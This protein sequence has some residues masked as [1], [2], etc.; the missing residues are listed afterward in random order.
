[1]PA[2]AEGAAG[3]CD[4]SWQHKSHHHH[5]QQQQ[6]CWGPDSRQQMLS[7]SSSSS[8]WAWGGGSRQRLQ[9]LTA[10]GHPPCGGLP[11]WSSTA[12]CSMEGHGLGASSSSGS[13][14][15]SRLSSCRD[16]IVLQAGKTHRPQQRCQHQCGCGV[17]GCS[18]GCVPTPHLAWGHPLTESSSR[19]ARCQS[20]TNQRGRVAGCESV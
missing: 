8:S 13:G 11:L 6:Q 14:L 2:A 16:V 17:W 5:Q 19:A 4:S 20:S 12:P 18:G 9:G 1:V 10:Y 15:C 7:S 3:V